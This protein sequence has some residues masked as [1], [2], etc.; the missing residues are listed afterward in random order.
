MSK[1]TDLELC[2]KIAEIEGI[3][4]FQEDNH[5][6]GLCIF[7]VQHTIGLGPEVYNPVTNWSLTGPLMVK[8]DITHE[9]DCDLYVT[10]AIDAGISA[11]DKDL[12]R[13]ILLAIV[14]KFEAGK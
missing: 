5:F 14:A 13:A 11:Y 1:L 3:H 6:H 10:Y 7:K 9:I 4:V 2:K 8:H 12:Q